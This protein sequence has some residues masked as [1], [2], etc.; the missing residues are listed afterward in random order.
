[1]KT[2]AFFF[3]QYCCYHFRWIQVRD[4]KL[5]DNIVSFFNFHAVWLLPELAVHHGITN[6]Y[7]CTEI[8]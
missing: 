2:H 8:Q 6:R 1:M 3:L 4:K 5:D 7:L